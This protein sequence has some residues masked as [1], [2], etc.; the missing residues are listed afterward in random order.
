VHRIPRPVTVRVKD[1]YHGCHSWVEIDRELPF[2]GTPVMA[3]EEFERARL[4]IQQ[5]CGEPEPAL[6]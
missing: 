1:D 6:A 3:D 2:E 4:E 5:I